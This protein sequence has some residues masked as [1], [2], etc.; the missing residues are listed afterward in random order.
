MLLVLK[1]QGCT[2]TG[3]Q[4]SLGG[5]CFSIGKLFREF[6]LRLR[7]PMRQEGQESLY[8][9]YTC[10]LRPRGVKGHGRSQLASRT[11]LHSVQFR[12]DLA[13]FP[14]RLR[15]AHSQHHSELSRG[16]LQ[17]GG[18]Q[19]AGTQVVASMAMVPW[20]HGSGP[21]FSHRDVRRARSQGLRASQWSL[22]LEQLIPL[23]GD[24]PDTLFLSHKLPLT[25][26]GQ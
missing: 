20:S 6:K 12:A 16:L 2:R 17:D 22:T 4:E 26:F 15:C 25:R 13:V 8:S 18:P 7:N 10:K 9:F 5:V 1:T 14:A 21:E 3:E 23:S 24:N 19:P 11:G